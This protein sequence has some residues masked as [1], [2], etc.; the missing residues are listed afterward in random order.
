MQ[1]LRDPNSDELCAEKSHAAT[2]APFLNSRHPASEPRHG[3][4]AKAMLCDDVH[5]AMR[6]MLT[7]GGPALRSLGRE[8]SN[9]EARGAA[10]EQVPRLRG[11]CRS[12]PGSD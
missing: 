3:Q 11:H 4:V 10:W 2:A 6:M 8:V 5:A 12:D 9:Y 7:T 1:P